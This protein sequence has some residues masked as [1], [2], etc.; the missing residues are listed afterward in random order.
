[1]FCTLLC[2][3]WRI[4]NYLFATLALHG[5]LAVNWFIAVRREEQNMHHCH[6]VR[7][8][9]RIDCVV[10]DNKQPNACAALLGKPRPARLH[11]THN[12]KVNVWDE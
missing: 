1:M 7:A 10:D 6:K 11:R 8:V 4:P 12:Y 2:N 9:H 3:V 5:T